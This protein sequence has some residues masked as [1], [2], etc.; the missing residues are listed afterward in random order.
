MFAVAYGPSDVEAQVLIRD[1]V[2]IQGRDII[3]TATADNNVLFDETELPIY[4]GLS[5]KLGDGDYWL[6]SLKGLGT[7]VLNFLANI[8]LFFGYQDSDATAKV[9]VGDAD[10]TAVNGSVVLTADAKSE[11]KSFTVGPWV[12]ATYLDSSAWS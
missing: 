4:G 2:V 11:A 1:G 9:L 10:I 5:E 12:A 3:V 7:S 8:R 6:K